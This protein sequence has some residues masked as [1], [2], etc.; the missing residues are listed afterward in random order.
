MLAQIALLIPC[1]LVRH[2]MR[3]DVGE[4]RGAHR[5]EIRPASIRI[6]RIFTRAITGSQR[7]NA[8]GVLF[9]VGNQTLVDEQTRQI[10]YR[11]DGSIQRGLILSCVFVRV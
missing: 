11:C 6:A 10:L 1:Q 2:R 9:T 7:L 4:R 5:L 3:L 8:L